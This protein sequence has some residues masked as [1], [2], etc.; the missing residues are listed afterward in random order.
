MKILAKTLFLVLTF[1]LSCKNDKTN[2]ETIVQGEINSI[3]FL[4]STTGYAVGDDY[5]NDGMALKTLDGGLNWIRMGHYNYL[6][7][8]FFVDIN[9]GY[10]V[11]L[12]PY[13]AGSGMIYNTTN[14]GNTWG[15]QSF[16]I[17][18][19]VFFTDLKNGFVVGSKEHI[20]RTQDGGSNW[21]I[22]MSSDTMLSLW[23]V[24]FPDKNI[25]YAVGDLGIILKTSDAGNTWMFQTSGVEKDLRSVFF[26]S[27]DTGYVTG[28]GIIMKTTNGGSN[29]ITQISY[30][31]QNFNSVY[32]INSN[33][34]YAVGNNGTILNTTNGGVNW[35]SQTTSLPLPNSDYIDFQSVYFIDSLTGYIGGGY[36][37]NSISQNPF[38]LKTTNGGSSWFRSF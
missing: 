33:C 30:S 28:A 2:E 21:A 23:S 38:I 26:T 7:S 11:G 13:G 10:M 5:S 29:W 15:I 31:S 19:S 27:E 25:G 24:H 14:G 6:N 3:N 37:G 4:N 8:V 35:S 16:E 32:F 22:V 34:G 18:H 20:L 1:C 36:S 17:L 12:H 9:N